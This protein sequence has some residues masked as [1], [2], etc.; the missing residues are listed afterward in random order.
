MAT[1]DGFGNIENR[2]GPVALLQS[3]RLVDQVL[4]LTNFHFKVRKCP[5]VSDEAMIKALALFDTFPKK[6]LHS[7]PEFCSLFY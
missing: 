2:A 5:G 3:L 4:A 7:I 1:L 6:R